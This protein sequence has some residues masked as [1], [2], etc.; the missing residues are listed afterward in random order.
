MTIIDLANTVQLSLTIVFILFC[1]QLLNTWKSAFIDSMR[2]IN[3]YRWDRPW[4]N[5]GAWTADQWLIVGIVTGF[6]GNLLDNVY[7]GLTWLAYQY[8]HP[9]H[10]YMYA[11]GVFANII[12]RQGI[13]M[14][15]VYCH[16]KAAKMLNE[17][18]DKT[19]VS[20]FFLAGIGS[21]ILLLLL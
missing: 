6:T 12:F 18:D 20:T 2:N 1:F 10:E 3:Y 5:S 21:L 4:R 13:G 16:L 15:A 19:N 14:W 17:K 7:W 8:D 11:G 9:A